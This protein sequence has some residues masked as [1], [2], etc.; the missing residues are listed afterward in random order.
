MKTY[1]RIVGYLKPYWKHL[2]ASIVFTIFSALLDGAS[3]YLSIPLLDTLFQQKGVSEG[4]SAVLQ[5]SGINSGGDFWI[6]REVNRLLNEIQTFIFAGSVSEVLIKI[7]ALIIIAFLGKNLFG[8]LQAYFLAFVEQGVIKDLRN[9][10]YR[11]LHKL[12]MS[13][14]KN[15]KTGNLISRIMN[16]VNAV[17]SSISAVFL[18]L[19]REPLKIVVFLGIA[20]AISWKLT[21]FSL[22]VLPF[23]LIVISYIGLIIRKQSG[24]LQQKIADLTNRLHETITGIKV[25]KAFGM[26]EYENRKFEEETVGFFRLSLKI[27]RIRNISSP[28]TEF[29]SVIV[30]VVIIYFGAQLVLVDKSIT[31][32][33]FIGFLFAI[34]Q[35]MPPVKELSSVNNRIQE[36][37]AAAD[38]IFEILDTEPSIKDPENPAPLHDFNDKLEFRN[39]SFKYEDS[40]SLVLDNI[41]F[42]ANKG[43]II[44]IVG[45]SGAGKT[46]LVDLIPRFYDPVEGAILLDGLDI[47]SFKIEDLRKLMGI[48]TQETVLFNDTVRNNIA[49]GLTECDDQKIIEAAKAA[50]AHK[51]IMELHHKYDTIIGEK[52][53]KLSGGQRQRISIARAILKNPPIMILDEATSALDNESEVLVQEAIERLLHN[54]TVFVIAHRLSTIRNADRILVLEQGKIVQDGKHEDL[55]KDE[56]GI[57]KKLYELQFRDIA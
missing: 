51:F 46:T 53:T 19:I 6:V 31:A 21:L 23:S 52:G 26:E 30:G 13:Y 16:D 35:L 11:H 15:E 45:S 41:N 42:T 7:C 10:A 18:N 9:Q 47:R 50:N 25:V 4:S 22:I 17:N 48:V 37:S 55:I 40:E 39:V 14:F 24:L 5:K 36:S 32:S 3:I 29:L 33:Q 44:A 2:T 49:Y 12:P 54:R 20:I 57:Y 34:F 56:E 38:R 1:F 27:T 8:Y 28:T 43:K